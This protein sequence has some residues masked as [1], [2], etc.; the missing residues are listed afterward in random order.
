MKRLTSFAIAHPRSVLALWL[1]VFI[2]AGALSI[3]LNGA[4]KAGGFTNPRGDAA[5]AQETVERAFGEAPNTLLVVLTDS[6]GRVAER[7]D[8]AAAA[9][10]RDGVSG[11]ADYRTHPEWISGDRRTTFLQVSF[12]TDF[13][14]VQNEVTAIQR[15][16]AAAVGSGVRVYTTGQPALDYQ[17][18]V[19]SKEDAARAEMIAFPVLFVVLLLVFRSVAAMVVPLVMAG[20]SLVISSGIGF[21]IAKSTDISIL[22]TNIVSLIGLAVAVD[23]SLFI[24]RRFR[25]E[26]ATGAAVEPALRRTM[27]TAGHS[28]LFSGFAVVVALSALFI[29]R[30]MAFTSIGIAG[31]VVTLVALLL[32]MTVLPAVLKLLGHRVNW[33]ELRVG[34]RRKAEQPAATPAR[35]AGVP[36]AYRRPGLLVT[37]LVL[38]FAALAA[39]MAQLTLQ[40]PVAS[41]TILPSDDPARVGLERIKDDLGQRGLF[42][43]QVV[44]TAPRADAVDSL[45]SATDEV[46]SVVR[47]DSRVDQVQAVSTLGIPP[48]GL[49]AALAGGQTPDGAAGAALRSLWATDNGVPVT[50][51]LV[52]AK[53]DPDTT[54]AHQL[55]KDLRDKLGSATS[56]GVTAKVTGATAI[57]IDFDN[58]VVTS[59]PIMIGAVA[60]V[61]FL[62]LIV[63]FGSVLL[64][65]L[66]LL[67]NGMVV[68]ASLGALALLFE[69][70]LG[71]QVNSVTPLL[72]FAVMFGLSM[73][74]M[75][76]IISRMRE[77]YLSGY[78]HRE[79]VLAGMRR[80]ATMVNGGAAIMVAVFISF[81]SA[82][83]SIVQEIGV[84]LSIAVLLDAVVV[85]L[86]LMPATLLLI[87]P[88][89][90][91]RRTARAVAH[92]TPDV[93]EATPVGA[94][95][96]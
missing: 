38:L 28:V 56:S 17:L 11:I 12:T 64:P 35:P 91:G 4:L 78:E 67:F 92:A 34:R 57:G 13:T 68:A 41:A 30:I 40:S 81:A 18:N 66:A 84:G 7:V 19:H 2:G 61:T 24:I 96:G 50:R 43:I 10:R 22:Y 29:P 79:A 69:D 60:A 53:D 25:E 47:A 63:A 85:R 37:G 93:D 51:V 58:V 31:V 5:I 45:L 15:D 32:S 74:Y 95:T 80:T 33:G 90:W 55:V 87:G 83:I 44:L 1:I 26:L 75:V 89:V 73:D 46:V 49:R 14:A 77:F 94:G 71:R 8:A 65:L 76:I 27:Q 86:L 70:A 36:R 3:G 20:S 6:E 62:I 21:L 48:A 59:I 23:Y 39:P 82:K 16:V 72:L 9:A 42:P 52:I 88:A 54:S